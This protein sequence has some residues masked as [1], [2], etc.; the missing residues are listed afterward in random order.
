MMVQQ[1][2]GMPPPAA[3]SNSVSP[4]GT[5]SNFIWVPPYEPTAGPLSFLNLARTSETVTFS[6]PLPEIFTTITDAPTSP[7][8]YLRRI[9]DHKAVGSIPRVLH[10]RHLRMRCTLPKPWPTYAR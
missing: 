2:R 7:H 5:R 1:P 3:K 9:R 8:H 4:V 10:R 6:D